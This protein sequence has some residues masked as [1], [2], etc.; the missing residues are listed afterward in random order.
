M[1]SSSNVYHSIGV[2]P[3]INCRGTFTIIGG[4]VELPEVLEA[5]DAASGYFV[6]YDELAAGVGRKLAEITGAEWGLVSAGCAA[7]IKH[8]TAAC[9]TGGNPEKLIRIPDLSGVEKTQVIAPAY[10]RN[11]YDH[12]VRNIGVEMITVDT[13]EEMARAINRKT[14][15]I[16]LV[17]VQASDPGQP[18]SLEVIAVLQGALWVGTLGVPAWLVW[19]RGVRWA[20]LGWRFQRRDFSS[21]LI[22]GIGTQL[23]AVPILYLPLVLLLEPD[24]VEVVDQISQ[25]EAGKAHSL[26]CNHCVKYVPDGTIEIPPLAPIQRLCEATPSGSCD[27]S[28]CCLRLF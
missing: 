19:V 17:T 5:M 6:Q 23:V 10:S 11:A 8:I 7:G 13:P 26:G 4:S 9:I 16:Y 21:G 25:P 15:M 2:E 3:I 1:G 14:A 18:F 27:R 20:D 22:I 12:A 24:P 28:K